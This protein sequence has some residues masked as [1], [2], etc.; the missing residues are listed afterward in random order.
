MVQSNHGRSTNK[1]G[2]YMEKVTEKSLFNTLQSLNT[3]EQSINNA[4]DGSGT[5][6]RKYHFTQK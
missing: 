3:R 4:M 5:C 1:P 2:N 6:K